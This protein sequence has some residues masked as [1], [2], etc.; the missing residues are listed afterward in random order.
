VSD[1]RQRPFEQSVAPGIIERHSRLCARTSG[2]ARCTCAPSF[3]ARVQF[4]G[5][6][7]E[8][9]FDDLASAVQWAADERIA[10][11]EGRSN[12]PTPTVR[13]AATVF[14]VRARDGKALTRSRRR[15][16]TNTIEQYERVL[17]LHVLPHCK[18]PQNAPLGDVQAD[19]LDTRT[20]Q[21]LV[22]SIAEDHGGELAR[23]AHACLSAVLRDLY[24]RG[25][26]D[27][28]PPAILLPPPGAGRD[29]ALTPAEAQSLLAAALVDDRRNQESLMYPL[30]ALLLGSGM[31]IGELLGLVWGPEGV[32]LDA[33][34]QRVAVARDVTKTD[35]GVRWIPLD[36]ETAGILE[37]H[38]RAS[39]G[40]AEG[41]LVFPRS[42][43]RQIQRGGVV[44]SRLERIVDEAQLEG[45]T[46]HTL[47]HTHATWGASAGVPITALAARLGHADPSFTLRRYAHASTRDTDAAAE[48]I[49]EHRR[50]AT[51]GRRDSGQAPDTQAG[52]ED[53]PT[54]LSGPAVLALTPRN[55]GVRGSS[56]RVG[57]PQIRS[58]RPIMKDRQGCHRSVR[59]VGATSGQHLRM[60]S[61]V[62]G[63]AR[64]FDPRPSARG[65]R[66]GLATAPQA[67]PPA[68]RRRLGFRVRRGAGTRA[69][70]ERHT[71][72]PL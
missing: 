13:A 64:Q 67:S 11:R 35:A 48:L 40:G 12:A 62:R 21:R 72:V 56:P 44:R 36:S 16:A 8:E 55:D 60:L 42:D 47:R 20:L 52:R 25:I 3:V 32:D 27:S 63:V 50:S 30:V 19:I 68:S 57:S 10:L 39:P 61:I 15:Y 5:Q 71:V 43:C 18:P 53:E 26:V 51:A 34:P 46:P 4:G 17:R 58:T 9:T 24:V 28:L 38:R 41:E 54:Q 66:D 65:P 7:S 1:S 59:R 45:V 69:R 23:Q 2:R 6:R 37:A 14:L 29:R 31:R 49:L 70:R 33:A 22:D